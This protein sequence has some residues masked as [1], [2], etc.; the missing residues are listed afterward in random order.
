MEGLKPEEAIIITS[1][2]TL[3]DSDRLEGTRS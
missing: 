2:R 1:G 3:L